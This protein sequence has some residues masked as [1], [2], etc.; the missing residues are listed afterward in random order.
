MKC[1]IDFKELDTLIDDL[2]KVGGDVEK[3]TEKALEKSHDYITPL[4]EDKCQSSNLPAHGKYAKSG[5][6]L[7]NLIIRDKNITWEGSK[8]SIDVG[9]DLQKSIVPIF[10]IRGTEKMNAVKGLKSTLE[11]K[12]TK[13]KIAEI[14]ENVFME[15]ITKKYGG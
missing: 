7:R 15:E 13:D 5:E 10:M 9:F 1:S 12:N 2:K 11:G 4:I 6:H 14:Q 8:C 3:T